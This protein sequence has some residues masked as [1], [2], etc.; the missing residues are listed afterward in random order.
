MK[1]QTSLEN[2]EFFGYHGLYEDEKAIGGMFK[3]D[4]VVEEEVD[5]TRDFSNLNQ[6]INYEH[7]FQIVQAE[8]QIRR[9]LIEDLAAAILVKISHKLMDHPAKV[10]VKI[11]KPDPGK[12][13]GSGAASV[14]LIDEFTN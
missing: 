10:T 8:M 5:E 3:V 12:R 9:N 4:V 2:L 13:F 6:L 14:T 1:L 11:T 7:L